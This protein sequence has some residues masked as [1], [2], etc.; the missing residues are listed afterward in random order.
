MALQATAIVSLGAGL[1]LWWQP[2]PHSDWGYYWSA[3]GDLSAYE[4]GGLSLWLLAL[5]KALGW[6]PVASSLALNLPAAVG[7]LL[8]AWHADPT[9]WRV[10]AQMTALYLLLIAPFYGIVQ[11][12]LIAAV[13]LGLGMWLAASRAPGASPLRLALGTVAVAFAVSTKPQ[14]AL[15]LWVLIPLSTLLMILRGRQGTRALALQGVLLAGSLL[16]FVTDMTMRQASGR[17]EQI[18]TSSAVTLYAG[19]LVSS[20]RR[21]EGCGYWSVEAAQAAKDDLG[22][23]M[24]DAARSRLAARPLSH[25]RAVVACKAPQI[26]SPPPYALY[27]LIESPNVRGRIDARA[28]R[29]D[30]QTRY[31]RVLKWEKRAYRALI[32]AIML[33]CAWTAVRLLRSG[34]AWGWL[35]VA[36]ILAFWAVHAVFEIQGR[37]F[38]GLY[39]LAPLW[40]ALALQRGGGSGA[41]GRPAGARERGA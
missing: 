37:Y 8:L 34:H 27:W 25:W 23:S 24:L 14:Y 32:L 29:D 18:R 33:A 26:I 17:T 35:T 31:Y 13:Q 20:D 7:A 5:P 9:R 36:W 16:G 19:L 39:L 28:D 1:A 6:S 40:C 11:L 10:M 3:A 30:F 41:G 12:D 4:R 22:R 21:E 2:A 15:V 38:L